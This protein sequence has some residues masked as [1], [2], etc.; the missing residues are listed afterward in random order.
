LTRWLFDGDHMVYLPKNTVIPVQHPIDVPEDVVLPSQVVDHFIEEASFHWVMDNCLCRQSE[1]CTDYPID[2]GCLFLGEAAR[3][4][5]PKLGRHVTREEALAHVRRCREAGLIHLIGRNKLDTMWKGVG[6][7]HKLLTICNCCP[8]CCLYGVLPHLAEHLQGKI[9]RMPGVQVTVSEQC[10]GCGACT[11]DVCFVDAI[12]MVA[13]RAVIGDG[14]VGCGRCIE[15]C[16]T[17]AIEMA[18]DDDRFVQ[19]TVER[20]SPLVDVR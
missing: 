20:I 14:C 5:N 10:V 16:P 4:I 7:G 19:E 2:L 11:R 1:G 6:P 3:E 15:A 8:C 17:G 13:G 12:R 18:V 9:T